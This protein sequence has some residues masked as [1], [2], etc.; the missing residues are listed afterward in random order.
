MKPIPVSSTMLYARWPRKEAMVPIEPVTKFVEEIEQF[1]ESDETSAEELL[2]HLHGSPLVEDFQSWAK[3][4]ASDSEPD[5]AKL[6]A[7]A[8]IHLAMLRELIANRPIRAVEAAR[9][10]V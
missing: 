3:G 5:P 7:V 1:V 10:K 2:L 9:P 8:R 6:R 4:L